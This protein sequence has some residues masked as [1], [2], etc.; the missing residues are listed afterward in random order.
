MSVSLYGSTV[1]PF[2]TMLCLISQTVTVT[3]SRLSSGAVQCLFWFEESV[4]RKQQCLLPAVGLS[5]TVVAKVLYTYCVL[6]HLLEYGRADGCIGLSQP[7][8]S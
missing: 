8:H 6:T 3:V 1:T 4:R 5:T 7:K 2:P